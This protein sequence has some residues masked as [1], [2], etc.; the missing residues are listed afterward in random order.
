M[1]PLLLSLQVIVCFDEA[2]KLDLLQDLHELMR[3]NNTSAAGNAAIE[4][5]ARD[6]SSTCSSSGGSSTSKRKDP[7]MNLIFPPTAT[8]TQLSQRKQPMKQAKTPQSVQT[9]QQ[10]QGLE[11]AH[12]ATLTLHP[13]VLCLVADRLYREST[14]VN[15]AW[16]LDCVVDYEVKPFHKYSGNHF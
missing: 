3:S 9:S 14:I 4:K 16:V 12:A 1:H 10:P 2:F 15:C 13:D 7:E 8:T 5:H 6:A 11:Q